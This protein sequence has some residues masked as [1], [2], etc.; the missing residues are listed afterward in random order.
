MHKRRLHALMQRLALAATLALLLVPT[1]G[2]LAQAGEGT[3]A[4]DAWGAMC[5]AAGLQLADHAHDTPHEPT[6]PR[7]AVPHHADDC[8]YCPLAQALVA[9]STAVYAGAA[10]LPDVAPAPTP[11][12]RPA[13]FRHPNGLGSRGPPLVS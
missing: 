9:P 7:P 3:A 4:H 11:T 8:A 10:P 2:R 5:T 13:S 12:A 1:L 6:A